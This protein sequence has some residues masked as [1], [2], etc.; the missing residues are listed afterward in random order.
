MVLLVLHEAVY[1]EP[2]RPPSVSGPRLGHSNHQTLPQS[3]SFTRSPVLLVHDTSVVVLAL[4][5]DR[6]VVTG[7]SKEALAAFAGKGPEV[8]ASSWLFTHSALLVL[9]RIQLATLKDYH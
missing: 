9:Q 3:A 6:L 5:D 4:L 2:V 7:S 8:E 1:L